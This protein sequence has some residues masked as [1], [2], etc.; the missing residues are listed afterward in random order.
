MTSQGRISFVA[1]AAVFL[2]VCLNLLGAWVLDKA[3]EFGTFSFLALIFIGLVIS[4]NVG[5]FI[6][7]GWM[8]KRIDLSKSY[9]L[10][11]MFFPG[12]A[13]L[14]TFEGETISVTQWAGISLITVGVIWLSVFVRDNVDDPAS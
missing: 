1:V 12:V 5:R 10:T 7:W 13:L 3:T 6:L 2:V 14:S 9:P 4:I 11:A 8:H